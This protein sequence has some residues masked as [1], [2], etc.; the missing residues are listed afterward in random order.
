MT[1]TVNPVDDPTVADDTQVTTLEDTKATIQ[2][3]AI[4]PDNPVTFQLMSGPA[5]GIV[6]GSFAPWEYTPAPNYAGTDSFTY[7]VGGG[8]Y[9]VVK[10]VFITVTP[11]NDVPTASDTS[12]TTNEDTAKVIT[13]PTND[14]DGD[15]VELAIASGPAHGTAVQSAAKSFLYT[16]AANY[17]GT[18]SFTYRASD[19]AATSPLRTVTITV[20]AVNDAPTVSPI[21][22][23]TAVYSDA[24][25][26]ITVTASDQESGTNLAWSQTGLPAGLTLAGRA[27]APPSV[28]P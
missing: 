21:G 13:P 26:P 20:N 10:T 14:V 18:D 23:V 17:S 2:P 12:A 19:G 25:M 22:G 9:I 28:A 7:A 5:H 4:D 16:P 11:F 3:T 8:G 6:T 15:T 24:I 1:V 27:G